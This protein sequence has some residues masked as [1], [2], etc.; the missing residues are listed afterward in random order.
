MIRGI[1]VSCAQGSIIWWSKVVAEGISFAIVKAGEGNKP[2]PD[3]M[4]ARNVAGARAAGLLVGAYSFLYPLP[5]KPGEPLHDPVAQAQYHFAQCSGLGSRDGELGPFVDAEWPAPQDF[6]KWGCSP[7]QIR[8]WLLAY[9]VEAER[10]WGR[11]PTLYTYPDW[12]RAIDGASEPAFARY[13]LWMASYP[14]PDRWPAEGETPSVPAPW[15]VAT[16]WQSS[17]GTLHVAGMVVD[18]DVFL[19][20]LDELKALAAKPSPDSTATFA[21]AAIAQAA[22][23]LDEPLKPE[24][25]PEAA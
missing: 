12:W 18:T 24:P 23:E 10:L 6:D 7:A 21:Q 16:F 4:F 13:G 14:H 22:A 9:L 15:K 20:T 5:P 1:D 17:G 25:P 3:P 19:G 8:A 2:G 11:V